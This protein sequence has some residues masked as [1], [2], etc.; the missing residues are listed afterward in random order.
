MDN[1]G[2]ATILTYILVG[3]KKFS[4]HVLCYCHIQKLCNLLGT[5]T[6]QHT[7]NWSYGCFRTMKVLTPLPNCI[8]FKNVHCNNNST[9]IALTVTPPPLFLGLV[10]S[11]SNFF[12]NKLLHFHHESLLHNGHHDGIEA[13]GDWWKG[14]FLFQ[15]I[16]PTIHLSTYCPDGMLV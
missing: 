6:T 16:Q 3:P 15:F 14:K 1:P 10:R 12:T 4:G 2:N 9:V 11:G 7:Q 5:F 8:S 13:Q